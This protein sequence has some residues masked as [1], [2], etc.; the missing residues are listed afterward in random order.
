MD[1][2]H[3]VLTRARSP[4]PP[5]SVITGY[6]GVSRVLSRVVI[7][8][9]PALPS[10]SSGQ[11]GAVRR[12]TA[13]APYLALLRVGFALPPMSPSGRCALTAPFHPYPDRSGR[14]VFCGTFRRVAPPGCYPA[15]CPVELGLS[16][17]RATS[18]SD[19]LARS[20][21]IIPRL[22]ALRHRLTSHVRR[23]SEIPCQHVAAAL[24]S[25][26]RCRYER[27]SGRLQR[28]WRN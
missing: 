5:V 18:G 22:G 11:P 20:T 17:P 16:S 9:G 1:V 6:R 10:A 25:D 19:H 21:R 7:Y 3:C 2:S 4:V 23:I 15:P 26:S 12:A 28:A 27:H 13:Y 24:P 8:L 14:C